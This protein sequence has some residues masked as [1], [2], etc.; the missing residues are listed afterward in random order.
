[1]QAT[2]AH[3]IALKI[4]TALLTLA[5][6]YSIAQ[7][8]QFHNIIVND[9]VS[10]S[11]PKHWHVRDINERKNIAAAAESITENTNNKN[12]QMHVSALSAVSTPPPVGAIIRV[13]FINTEELTQDTINKR[14]RQSKGNVINEVSSGF[15]EEI[16]SLK[17]SLESQQ[18]SMLGKEKIGIDKIDNLTA[19]TFSYRRTSKIGQSPFAVTQYHI[20]MGTEKILITLSYRESD[21]ILFKPILEKVKRSISIKR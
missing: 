1:M 12:K 19:F 15:K 6:I 11:I 4:A 10:I 20:P 9:K 18:L 16:D 8:S 13:S 17:S 7:Q 14:I 2:I 3:N 21:E 5:P